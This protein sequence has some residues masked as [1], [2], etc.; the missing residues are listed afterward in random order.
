MLA[1]RGA[2]SDLLSDATLQAMAARH[3]ACTIFTVPGQG[4]APIL[5]GRDMLSR[6]ARLC[7]QADEAR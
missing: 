3:P 5:A 1:L 6:I 2:H 7:T 4:H